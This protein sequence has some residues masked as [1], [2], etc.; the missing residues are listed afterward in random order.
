MKEGIPEAYN[1]PQI[2][3]IYR[4]MRYVVVAWLVERSKAGVVDRLGR[5]RPSVVIDDNVDHKILTLT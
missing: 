3:V 1:I 2:T 4:T 5:T